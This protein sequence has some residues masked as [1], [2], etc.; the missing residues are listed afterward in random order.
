LIGISLP[1]IARNLI[2]HM[3]KR[4]TLVSLCII[5]PDFLALFQ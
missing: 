2:D 5:D 3:G 1:Q 4:I